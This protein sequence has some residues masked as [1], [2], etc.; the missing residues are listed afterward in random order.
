MRSVAYCCFVFSLLTGF[1][2]ASPAFASEGAL[3][4]TAPDVLREGQECT[5]Q[6]ETSLPDAVSASLVISGERLP[7]G[8]KSRGSFHLALAEPTPLEASQQPDNPIRNLALF[9]VPGYYDTTSVVVSLKIFNASGEVALRHDLPLDHLPA[10]VPTDFVEG[11]V[12]SKDRQRMYCLKEGRVQA[13]FVVSTGR[14]HP[15]GG[16]PT[17]SL[18]SR[19]INKAK[20]AWSRKYEV[21][22]PYWNA[23]TP[24][25]R[26]GIHATSPNL[27]PKLGTPD[28]H[29]CVRLHKQDARDFFEM[30]PVGTRVVIL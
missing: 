29:G 17:P 13:G 7:V 3:V 2:V 26:Y 21:T 5:F 22:M 4:F 8:G 20:S 16:G 27:Y 23:I 15:D 18:D 30:F 28:S 25:G 9:V 10:F 12:I 1:L 19:I 14:R 6:L 24:D 11:I